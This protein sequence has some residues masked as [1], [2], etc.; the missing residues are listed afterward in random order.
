MKIKEISTFIVILVILVFLFF[1]FVQAKEQEKDIVREF[2]R[3]LGR[4]I[5]EWI[6]YLAG[7]G[8]AVCFIIIASSSGDPRRLSDAKKALVFVVIG[9]I[10]AQMGHFY[11]ERIWP[12]PEKSFTENVKDL[13]KQLGTIAA[14]IGA[15][16][17]GYGVFEIATSGGAPDKLEEGKTIVFWSGVAVLLG[18]LAQSGGI[19]ARIEKNVW[20]GVF[21]L[22]GDIAALVSILILGWGIF[23]VA[24]S[25]GDER[26]LVIGKKI[27]LWGAIGIL[28]GLFLKNMENFLKFFGIQ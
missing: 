18:I 8:I 7:L 16:F 15:I 10:I 20:A 5:F 9:F 28:L 21:D 19:M 23:L 1:N 4:K 22:L 13:I 17:L 14:I 2:F 11:L 12:F 25:G 27:I 6:G 24:T 3:A 26:N